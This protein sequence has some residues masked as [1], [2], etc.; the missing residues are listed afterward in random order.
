M[1]LP[2]PVLADPQAPSAQAMP[3][4]PPSGVGKVA[5]TSPV[6]GSIF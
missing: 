3:A 6:S 1:D 4:A 5:S 2:L